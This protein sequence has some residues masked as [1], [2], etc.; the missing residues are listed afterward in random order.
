[1]GTGWAPDPA[2]GTGSTADRGS[3]CSSIMVGG[4]CLGCDL[5]RLAC[6]GAAAIA[7]A[8]A[9]AALMRETM[10]S[11][12]CPWPLIFSS[13]SRSEG[14]AAARRTVPDPPGKGAPVMKTLAP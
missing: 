3:A 9:L 14:V 2:G 11:R 1:M 13:L 7:G 10:A 5:P 4:G 6:W 12:A 8:A